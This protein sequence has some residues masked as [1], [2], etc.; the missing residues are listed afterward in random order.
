MRGATR[1]RPKPDVQET[2]PLLRLD[3][4]KTS[5]I[6]ESVVSQ[7]QQL[8]VEGRLGPGDKL[9][10]ERELVRRFQVGRSSIRDALRVLE[11]MGLVKSRQGGG[12]VVQDLSPQAIAAPLASMLTRKAALVD[13]LMD[14]RSII[15]PALAARAARHA[16]DEQIAAMKEILQRQ[17]GRVRRGELAVEEDAEFHAAIATAAG[18]RVM[19][20]VLDVLMDLLERTRS[21]TLQSKGRALRS[22][23]SHRRIL[24]AIERR[25]AGS[26]ERAMRNH[27]AAVNEMVRKKA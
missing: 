20:S 2:E 15:E 19:L 7:L 27:L 8:V 10:S 6:F 3:A 1:P 5:R 26:A 4:V 21:A 9:P 25:T 23:G 12:T 16:T 11:A 17:R 24:R 14:V 18:N 22:L 13:E